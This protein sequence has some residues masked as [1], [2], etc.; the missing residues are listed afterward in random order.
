MAKNKTALTVN[1]TVTAELGVR[2]EDLISVAVAQRERA[3]HTALNGAQKESRALRE[4]QIV[5]EKRHSA[6]LHAAGTAHFSEKVAAL[7]AAFEGLGSELK[8]SLYL[9]NGVY[10][11]CDGEW[12]D[13]TATVS[14]GSKYATSGY[15]GSPQVEVCKRV[16]VPATEELLLAAAALRDNRKD[17][18]QKMEVIHTL[19]EEV[20]N[21]ASTE[22]QARAALAEATLRNTETGRE[23]LEAMTG[24]N[25]LMTV[26]S[27]GMVLE[28]EVK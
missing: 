27:I 11:G 24:M 1:P 3:L 16:V 25:G 8:V 28:A 4:E 12:K 19:K 6:V 13:V 15:T 26:P 2:N 23:L 9:D 7:E 18:M 22:R 17:Q 5:L 14:I 21:I 20:R 10:G